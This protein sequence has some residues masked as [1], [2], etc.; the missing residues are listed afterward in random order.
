MRQVIMIL[1]V[2]ALVGS[3]NRSNRQDEQAQAVRDEMEILSATI[4]ELLANPAEYRDKEVALSGMVT[5]VCRHGGQKCFVLADDG[6]TQLRVVTGGEMDE[7]ATSLEGSTVAFRG[8]FRV[9][10]AAAG[11]EAGDA[12]SGEHHT[13]EMAHSEAEQSDYF[14]EALDLREIAQQA[15]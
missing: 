13:E 12:E 10:D 11:D 15:E 7:F 14:I 9:Q 1:V 4:Q 5:H 2:A 6:E 3:C 8:I